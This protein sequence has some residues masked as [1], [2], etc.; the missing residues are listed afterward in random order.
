MAQ[1]AFSVDRSGGVH[2]ARIVRSSGSS[3]LDESDARLVERAAPLPPPPAGDFRHADRG[4]GADPLR[5]A[6]RLELAFL[7]RARAS[8]FAPAMSPNTCPSITSTGPGSAACASRA[9]SSPIG[10]ATTAWFGRV[11]LAMA[12]AGVAGSS[13]SAIALATSAA[14]VATGM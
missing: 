9:G 12:T 5:H 10:A 8:D 13:P 14:S 11:A 6:L 2:H 1:L 3:L 4:L 7:I